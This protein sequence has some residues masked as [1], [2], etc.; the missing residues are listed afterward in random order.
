MLGVIHGGLEDERAFHDQFAPHRMKGEWFKGEILPE[1]MAIVRRFPIDQPAPRNVIVYS[2]PGFPDRTLV[3]QILTELHAANPI[4]W[5]VTGGDREAERWSLE[6]AIKNKVGKYCYWPQWRK[7]G[8]YAAFK[9]VPRLLGSM[10]DP[11]LYLVFQVG[12]G[13]SSSQKLIRGA[14]KQK[15]EVIIKAL[16]PKPF[17]M[18]A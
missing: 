12:S 5:I 2:D 6:W 10:F 15:C 3:L 13:S 17:F 14:E 9:M 11:K 7:Y 1:V 4:A 8:R 18:P 16:E